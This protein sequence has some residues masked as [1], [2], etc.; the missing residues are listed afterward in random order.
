MNRFFSCAVILAMFA[1]P[2]FGGMKPQTVVVG[3]NIS[4]GTTQLPAG[5]YKLTYTGSGSN[6][7]VTLMQGRK[8]AATFTAKEVAVKNVRGVET[9]SRGGVVSLVAIQIKDV[10]LELVDAPQT[11]Q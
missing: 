7:Q 3:Q 1:A 4:V 2:A 8:T 11:G 9:T 6:V 10:R 5:N